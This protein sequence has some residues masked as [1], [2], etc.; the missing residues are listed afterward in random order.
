MI[1]YPIGLVL[2]YIL[3]CNLPLIVYAQDEFEDF[4]EPKTTI[5]G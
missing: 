5:G 2:L 4:F 1:K 3:F